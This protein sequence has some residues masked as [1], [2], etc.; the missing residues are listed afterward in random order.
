MEGRMTVCNMSI[1]G[2]ARAGLVPPMRRLCRR[3]DASRQ[4]PELQLE[5]FESPET[6][7][8]DKCGSRGR[9][10][11]GAPPTATQQ[12]NTDDQE[13][14]AWDERQHQADEAEEQAQDSGARAKQRRK[15][16]AWVV[17]HVSRSVAPWRK[18]VVTDQATAV[19]ARKSLIT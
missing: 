15:R 18:A 1:E 16:G 11:A 13:R 17:I 6:A 9:R 4:Q 3:R 5:L 8:S 12:Q 7:S 19:P 2:G 14:N 10:K